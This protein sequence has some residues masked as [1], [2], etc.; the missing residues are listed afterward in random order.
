MTGIRHADGLV[1]G[2]QGYMETARAYWSFPRAFRN[3]AS[4]LSLRCDK[5]HGV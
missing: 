3:S 4:N 2:N 1:T 5:I